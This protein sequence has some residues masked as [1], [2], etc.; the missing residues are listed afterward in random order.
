MVLRKGVPASIGCN[1]KA[2]WSG[3]RSKSTNKL[4]NF[5]NEQYMGDEGGERGELAT[6]VKE[7]DWGDNVCL[8]YPQGP[9][10]PTNERP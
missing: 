1:Q 2:A 7:Q 9:F 5:G 3:V 6:D 4:I 10:P 8:A